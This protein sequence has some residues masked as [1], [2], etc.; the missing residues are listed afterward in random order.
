[1]DKSTHE[2][3]LSPPLQTI[4]KQSKKAVTFLSVYNGTFNI[5]NSNNK[6]YSKKSLIEE[7]FIQII[8]PPGAHELESLNDEIKRIIIAKGHYTEAEYPFLITA[9]FKT[10]GSNIERKPKGAIIGFVFDD[11]LRN[12]LGFRDTILFKG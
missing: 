4:I 6:F 8:I 3:H 11:S 10:L 2:E 1:M 12:L 7:D 9:N 5:T